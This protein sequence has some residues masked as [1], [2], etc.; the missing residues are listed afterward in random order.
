MDALVQRV[1]ARLLE[2]GYVDGGPADGELNEKTR[3]QIVVFRRR[4]GLPLTDTID[5]RLLGALDTAGAKPIPLI[6][7][8]ATA[9]EIA[10]KVEAMAAVTSVVRQT[11]WQKFV[12][13]A[14]GIPAAVLSFI[15]LVVGQFDTVLPIITAIRGVFSEVPVTVWL[16][17]FASLCLLF[18]IQAHGAS[19]TAQRSQEAMKEGYQQGTVKNDPVIPPELTQPEDGQ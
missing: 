3:D 4:N 8:T 1:Q 6:Q 10:P 18:A 5:D 12:A 11:W 16:G 2:L 13:W 15:M 17:G 19:R 7:A 14:M 9:E